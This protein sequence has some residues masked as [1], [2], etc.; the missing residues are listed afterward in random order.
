MTQ[1]ETRNHRTA[2]QLAISLVTGLIVM[3][4]L[5]PW[6]G[7][8]SDPPQCF[9]MFDYSVPCGSGLAFAAGAT[10]AGAVGLTQWLVS[11]SR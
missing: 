7:V 9:S 1:M 5:L 2:A 8:D 11:R 4:A 6:H 10:A 3:F